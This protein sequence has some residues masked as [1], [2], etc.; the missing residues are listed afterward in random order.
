MKSNIVL[1]LCA[2]LTLSSCADE[3]LTPVVKPPTVLT[4]DSG[5][6][7]GMAYLCTY[8]DGWLKY[9]NKDIVVGVIGS[10]ISTTTDSLGKWVLHGLDSGM[11]TLR[12]T[13]PGQYDTSYAYNVYSNGRD[14]VFLKE[15]ITD[16]NW[17]G[18]QKSG[19]D[20]RELPPVLSVITCE[21]SIRETIHVDTVKDHG[22]IREIRRDTTY[23]WEANFT[24]GV[25]APNKDLNDRLPVSYMC[26]FTESPTLSTGELPDKPFLPT[27]QNKR[28]GYWS[29]EI[30]RVPPGEKPIRSFVYNS[31]SGAVIV[32]ITSIAKAR[33]ITK[34]SGKKLYF[35]I[36]PI[37]QALVRTTDEQWG[38]PNVIRKQNIMSP[39]Q[40]FEI[41]WR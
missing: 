34:A 27:A 20:V 21:T 2:L 3:S 8:D 16:L 12:F 30:E 32:G 7:S 4:T 29:E 17:Q 35:H 1:A 41:Q 28:M 31:T 14:S 11:H 5:I 10:N 40:S 9:G 23:N 24:I 25:D 19:G 36:I 37:C 6:V 13:K 15:I 38:T 33:G 18:K 22:T 39:A 26:C